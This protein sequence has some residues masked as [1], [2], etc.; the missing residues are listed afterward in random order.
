MISPIKEIKL[1][2]Y[3]LELKYENPTR[4]ELE[5]TKPNIF[6]FEKISNLFNRVIRSNAK[7]KLRRK[8]LKYLKIVKSLSNWDCVFRP[9]V[10]AIIV[11]P[12]DWISKFT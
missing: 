5:S 8:Q 11:I 1:K 2:K 3:K 7:D 6:Q 12:R 4:L 10:L 9:K